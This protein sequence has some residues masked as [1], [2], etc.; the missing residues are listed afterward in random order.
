MAEQQPQDPT[1]QDPQEPQG[2]QPPATPQ[3]QQEPPGPVPYDRFAEVNRRAKEAEARL[4]QLEADRKKAEETALAEQNKYKELYEKREQELAAERLSNTRLAVAMKKGI[5]ADLAN[6]LQGDTAED[7]AVDADRL[8]AFL[9][10]ASGPGVP[11]APRTSQPMA[12]DWEKLD[13]AQIRKA[14]QPAT[15]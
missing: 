8:L 13:P 12:V 3:P 4:Q 1:P 5:P 7:I 10:P 15:E 14:M 6:R 11:P 2:Q 9:K